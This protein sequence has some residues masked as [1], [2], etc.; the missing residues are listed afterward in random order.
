M[1]SLEVK[2]LTYSYNG[3]DKILDDISFTV[4]PGECVGI[5]GLNG[6]GKTTLCYCLCGIIP[7]FYKGQMSG[8]VLVNNTD[9]K[10]IHLH[11]LALEIGIVFQDPNDQIIMPT[12]EDEIAF[13]MENHGLPR[14][15]M[16]RRID[17]ITELLGIAGLKGEHPHRLSGGEKQLVALATALVLDPGIIVFDESLAMLDDKTSN[18]LLAM[19][20]TLKKSGKTLIIV[21]HTG[22]SAHLVG[23]VLVLEEGRIVE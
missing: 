11:K 2:S 22:K 15:E 14:D 21:D 10:K 1:H 19:I 6:S 8:E 4:Q 20:E 7:Y 13:V 3:K 23:R 9:T 12:V 16:T 5:S 18:R 17:K